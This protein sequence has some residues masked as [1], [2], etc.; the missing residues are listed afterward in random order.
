M[1]KVSNFMVF[2]FRSVGD[3]STIVIS[4]LVNDLFHELSVESKYI[5]SRRISRVGSR[6]RPIVVELSSLT[7]VRIVLKVK[8]KICRLKR[9]S[10]VWFD[11]DLTTFQRKQHSVLRS[12]LKRLCNSDE[13][14]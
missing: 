3:E 1:S 14:D 5:S 10:K 7:N 11:E 2:N 8:S 4:G 13:Y 12:D 6:L 9:W